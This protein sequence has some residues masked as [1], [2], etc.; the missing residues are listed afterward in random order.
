MQMGYQRGG[1]YSYDWLDRQFGYLDRPSATR[2]LPQFQHLDVGDIIPIGRSVG[3]PVKAL[4][5]NRML[6][7]CARA[8]GRDICVK[9]HRAR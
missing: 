9:T 5:P 4:T 2:I 1:L 6:L 3:F 8:R 7:G